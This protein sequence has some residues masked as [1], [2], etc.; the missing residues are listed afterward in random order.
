MHFFSIEGNTQRLDGGA[1]FGNA[2]K[3]LWE[4]WISADASNRISL[5]CRSLLLQDSRKKNILFEAGVGAF[6]EPK[7][8]KRYGIFEEEHM[9]IKNLLS[10]GISDE[11]VDI[12]ILS[13]LH[14]DHAG[15]LLSSFG[16]GEMRLLF[17]NATI[18]VSEKQWKR[19]RSPLSRDKTSFI[20]L[21]NQL[22]EDSGRLKFIEKE[23]H[24]DFMEL[25]I[26]FRFSEGHTPGLI[27][28]EIST[29]Q[30]P[31]VFATDL[32]PALPWLHIPITP[33]YDR[34]PELSIQE[35]TFFLEEM[36]ERKG[37]L[38]LTHD[39]KTACIEIKRDENGKY[40]GDPFDMTS[41][42]SQSKPVS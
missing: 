8:K 24:P 11:D 22:L 2:P 21:I 37:K 25:G 15:G 36:I 35:K 19:A 23:T 16:D 12:I 33:A 13:H 29:K 28:S 39:P 10:L 17:P 30:G 41:L 40:F 3:T 6:F 38:F 4:K 9:L 26:S 18:Y 42:N 1:M 32:I 27:L 14:F 20:P 34:F 7:L 5:A 31:L